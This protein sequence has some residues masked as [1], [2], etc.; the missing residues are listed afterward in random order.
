MNL[1]AMLARAGRSFG[2]R[3]AL[4]YGDRTLTYREFDGRVSRLA[5]ALLQLGLRK[6]DRVMIFQRNQPELLETVFACFRA[7]LVAVPVNARLHPQEAAYI[8]ADAEVSALVFSPEFGAVAQACAEAVPGLHL[9]GTGRGEGVREYEAFLAA[10]EPVGDA[11]VN[12]DDVAWLFYTSGT[13]GR[14]KG[15]MLTH[16][17]LWNMIMNCLADV[18]AA[19]AEDVF[20]HAAPLTHGSGLYAMPGILKGAAQVIQHTDSFDPATYFELIERHRVTHATFLAPTMVN[21]LLSHPSFGRNDLSSLRYLVYG[22]GPMHVADVKRAVAALGPVLVQIYGQGEAP[23]TISFLRAREH[24]T[25]GDP[26]RERRLASAGIPHADVAVRIVDEADRELP[27]G[28]VGEICVRGPIVMKGYWRNPQATAEA[29]RGGWLHTGDVG[30]LDDD[31]YLYILDRAKDLII[32]GGSNI[33]PREVEE[34][35]LRHPAVLEA[36]VFGVPD[37]L[38]GEAVKA[39]VALRPGMSATEGELIEWC[40]A[41][42]AGYK[43]PRSVEFVPSL[44]KNAYGKVLRRELRDA[45]WAGRER[46]V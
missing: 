35:L 39:V 11:P 15:A 24:V 23:M 41:H 21:M 46:R 38:W 20:L 5:G 9:I 6:D 42:L 4:T 16:G 22:G 2:D 3:P 18:F 43:K 19:E 25:D 40:R 45:H 26:V 17:N 10:G 31:G 14:P 13:T 28:E 29:L 37:P 36:A 8:A 33:Y 7:G 32:S 27:A 44:P 30:R 34:V 12:L 1:A